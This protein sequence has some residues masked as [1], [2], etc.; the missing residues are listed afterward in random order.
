MNTNNNTDNPSDISKNKD[1][2]PP[3]YISTSTIIEVKLCCYKCSA[4]NK[5]SISNT[6]LK[7]LIPKFDPYSNNMDNPNDQGKDEKQ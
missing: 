3:Q 5:I 7:E 2:K 4:E 6:H 1:Q